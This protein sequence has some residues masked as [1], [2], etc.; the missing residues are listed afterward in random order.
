MII[1]GISSL[2]DIIDDEDSTNV[3]KLTR[4]LTALSMVGGGLTGLYKTLATLSAGLVGAGA[5]AGGAATGAA[6][7]GTSSAAASGGVIALGAS[8][9]IAFPEFLAIAV[10]IGAVVAILDALIVTQKEAQEAI[11]DANEAYQD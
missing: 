11:E 1:N 10:A 4:A 2:K 5:A 9:K 3:E 7:L 6:A 8:I